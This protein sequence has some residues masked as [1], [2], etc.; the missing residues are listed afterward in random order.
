MVGDLIAQLTGDGGRPDTLRS[1]PCDLGAGAT[2]AAFWSDCVTGLA[3]AGAA[4]GLS[5][6]LPWLGAPCPEYIFL[7]DM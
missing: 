4:L 5:S 3:I 1:D 7:S 2:P 6:G